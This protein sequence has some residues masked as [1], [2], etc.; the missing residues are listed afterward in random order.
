HLPDEGG[1]N[2]ASFLPHWLVFEE[3]SARDAP[4]LPDGGNDSSQT[5]HANSLVFFFAAHLPDEGGDDST[6]TY[7]ANSLVFFLQPIYQMKEEM[8]LP[9]PT[10]PTH[11][12]VFEE[13]STRDAH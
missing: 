10:M 1:D 6:Q 5:Y 3:S 9:K 8:I 12:L 2:P 4:H 11:W 13:S 7:H